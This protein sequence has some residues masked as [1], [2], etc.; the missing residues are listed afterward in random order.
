M[1]VPT[2]PSSLPSRQR[3]TP[4]LKGFC[5]RLALAFGLG[6]GALAV[7]AAPR[8][9]ADAC[10]RSRDEAALLACRQ[11]QAAASERRVERLLQQLRE[12]NE[13]DEPELWQ[14][15]LASQ[16]RWAQYRDAE[17]RVRNFE[18]RSGRA[19]EAYRLA[20][21]ASLNRLRGDDLQRQV[22]NP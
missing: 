12:R 7:Q 5:L 10:A 21:I 14:L 18:S 13:T 1:L 4:R 3:K 8:A 6:L 22:D 19:Y 15:Q 20:C 17:C 11:E 16:A 9:P 2:L